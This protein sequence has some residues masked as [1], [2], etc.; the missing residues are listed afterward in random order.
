ML[1]VLDQAPGLVPFPALLP[2]PFLAPT[3]VLLRV[4]GLVVVLVSDLA[5]TLVQLRVPS[6]LWLP[7]QL[8]VLD[9][10]PFLVLD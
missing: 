5:L 7:A 8:L 3:L 1:L 4:L 10:V 9:R 2:V 6:L